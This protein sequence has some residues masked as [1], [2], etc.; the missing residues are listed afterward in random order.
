MQGIGSLTTQYAHQTYTT[1]AVNRSIE[2]M[3]TAG[4]HVKRDT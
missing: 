4:I 2:A 3:Q 1:V